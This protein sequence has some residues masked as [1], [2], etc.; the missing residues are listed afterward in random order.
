MRIGI[1]PTRYRYP[2][3]C[4]VCGEPERHFGMHSLL[5]PILVVDVTSP[6]SM[7]TDHVSKREDY[8]RIPS[9]RHYLIID[10]VQPLI[11][12]YTR[13]DGD[14]RYQR[15]DSLSDSIPLPALDIAL[16]LAEV[17]HGIAL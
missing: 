1:S 6:S 13:Q 12:L 2:D 10:Q 3:L 7:R 8:A 5:N 14:W 15:F 9:V 4:V 11:E 16:P 17:Y